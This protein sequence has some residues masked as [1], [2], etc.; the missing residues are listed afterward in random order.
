MLVYILIAVALF[1]ALAYALLEGSHGA[2][3]TLTADEARATA[4]EVIQYGDSLRPKIDK[5]MLFNSVSDTDS[6][7]GSGILFDPPGAGTAP[8][9]RELFDPSGGHASYETPPTAACLSACSYVFTGQITMTGAGSDTNPEL[10]M[11][12]VDV[13]EEVCA[14][15]NSVLGYG[16][17]IP[18]GGALATVTPFNGTNYGAATAVTLSPGAGVREL[19]YQ[20]SGGAGRYIYVNVVR[21]R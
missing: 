18:T 21:A 1:A 5:L 4:I 10:S 3:T 19:C 15:I 9:T 17:A 2:S 11:I 7:A 16:T 13:P 6:P 8:L 12:L 14:Q 20:E